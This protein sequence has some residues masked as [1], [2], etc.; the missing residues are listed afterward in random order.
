MLLCA[1]FTTRSLAYV[2]DFS[3]MGDSIG[4]I[5]R[6][7]LWTTYSWDSCHANQLQTPWLSLAQPAFFGLVSTR[8][9]S[10]RLRSTAGIL[11]SSSWSTSASSTWWVSIM[12][13]QASLMTSQNQS[14]LLQGSVNT[15]SRC[16][17]VSDS[18]T[19]STTTFSA[20]LRTQDKCMSIATSSTSST[21]RKSTAKFLSLGYPCMH[22][23]GSPRFPSGHSCS[24]S[25]I[26]LH[27]RATYWRKNSLTAASSSKQVT[28]SCLRS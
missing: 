16:V 6:L 9:T 10:S 23:S 1:N 7:S 21:S 18:L 15:L 3:F 5:S 20:L 8:S 22:W 4:G 25:L 12:K 13:M 17:S 11:I 26:S 2:V 24:S 14:T 27:R 19:L 28:W